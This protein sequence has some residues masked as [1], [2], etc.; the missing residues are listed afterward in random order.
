MAKVVKIEAYVVNDK[1]YTS[2][3]EA[4]LEG[5]KADLEKFVYNDSDLYLSNDS[6]ENVAEFI[7]RNKQKI[8]DYCKTI[9]NMEEE[10]KKEKK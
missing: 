6:K 7:I 4:M 2:F 1:T 10:F 9:I 5:T 3:T 8:Y